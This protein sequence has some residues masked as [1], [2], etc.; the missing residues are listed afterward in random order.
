MKICNLK[1]AASS[2]LGIAAVTLPVAA[3]A[4]TPADG[5]NVV[6]GRDIVVTARLREESLQDIPL[7]IT[8]FSSEQIE[9]ERLLRVEDISR[10]TAGLTY[11][12]GG[13]PNDTRPALR[14]MQAERGR[15]SVAILLDGQDLSG[16]NLSIAG[17]TAALQMN[18]FDLERV[19]VVKG[20]QAA[21]YGRNAFAGAISY[22]SKAPSMEF[23]AKATA[24]VASGGLFGISGSVTGP[25]VKDVL[26]FRINA[27]YRESG[28]FYRNPLDGGRLGAEESKGFAAALLLKP[29]DGLTITGRYQYSKDSA[30]DNPTAFIPSNTRLPVPGGTFAPP[31]PPG[32][33]GPPQPQQPCPASLTGASATI[34]A[35]CTRGSFVGVIS[36]NQSNIQAGLN[37]LTGQ[38]PFGLRGTSNIGAV[39]AE[40]KTGFGTFHYQ[41]GYLKNRS[42]IEQ[43]GDFSNSAAPPGL[44]LSLQ[45]LQD[46][47]YANRHYDH[48]AY[49]AYDKDR[50][51]VLLG[52][53]RFDEKS[54]LRNASQFWL[55][56]PTS[57]LGNPPFNLSR[58]PIANFRFPSITARD[59]GY[60]GFFGSASVEIVD[61]FKVSGEARYN[62]DTIRYD[63]SGWRQ[64]D[65]SLS[66]LTPTCLP[67]FAN[68]AVF[69]P[70]SPATTPPPGVVV[71]CPISTTLKFNKWT[72]RLTAEYSFNDD[73]LTYVSWAKGFKPGGAN[74][75]EIV[76]FVG[77]TFR[78]ETVETYEAGIKTSLMNNRVTFNVDAYRNRYRDQQIGV[79]LTSLGAGGQQVTSA[80]IINAARVNIWGIEADLS[81]RIADKLT[82]SGN[83]AYTKSVFDSFI[84]GPVTGSPAAAFAGC[85]VPT[86]QSSSSQNLAES[87]NICADFSGKRVGKSP[88]HALNLSALWREDVG[89]ANIFFQFDSNYR[90]KRFVDESNLASLRSS[91]LFGIKAGAEIGRVSINMYVDNLFEQ[92]RI[93]SAQRVVDFGN[94][95]GFAPGRAFI[96]YLPRPRVFG[97]S[98][99]AKY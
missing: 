59:T 24:E 51:N 21:L 68:G 8:A 27:N 38:P 7:A 53:Q 26:A 36:A 20:P 22:I 93:Q 12:I 70:A 84:Q 75:N 11:D 63:A 90:S 19:E 49:W 58:G 73:I 62:K 40:W 17:G 69:S 54:T 10:Q 34:V 99:S 42:A 64:Q 37:P 88:K 4:Q 98:V 47:Q 31:G 87:G 35:A 46:L 97:L 82:L 96:A 30:S 95:E 85:G 60:N 33:P 25:I 5:E 77:Q 14:G 18:L 78:P 45:V 67:N 9:R 15:P 48:T 92:K 55:R 3:Q 94:P 66:R 13:F 41:F 16:E 65:V 50:F 32:P 83:Y 79:Q 28:G 44:V 23:A 89:K 1:L 76:T 29:T 6:D 91:W 52:Y 2:L 57:A 86:T 61:G 72:P 80:G 39:R 81:W 56:S 43:D 71:A 74:T